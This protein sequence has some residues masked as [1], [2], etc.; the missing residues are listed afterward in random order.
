LVA[1]LPKP[2]S[3][4]PVRKADCS[5]PSFPAGA[6]GLFDARLRLGGLD[7]EMLQYANRKTKESFDCGRSV[8]SGLPRNPMKPMRLN[9]YDATNLKSWRRLTSTTPH[10]PK[11]RMPLRQYVKGELVIVINSGK[12]L[13][14]DGREEP[15]AARKDYRRSSL[16]HSSLAGGRT[17]GYG[18]VPREYRANQTI[19]STFDLHTL[20]DRCMRQ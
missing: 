18:F 10:S 6:T 15:K 17:S 3:D 19:C 9:P 20:C 2:E 7:R 12:G 5:R 14:G 11:S 8:D 4:E 16:R 1:E 13:S